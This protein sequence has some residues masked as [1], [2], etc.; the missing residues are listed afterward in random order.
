[1]HVVYS[2]LLKAANPEEPDRHVADVYVFGRRSI[3]P[4]SGLA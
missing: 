3:G 4:C 1:M 2:I